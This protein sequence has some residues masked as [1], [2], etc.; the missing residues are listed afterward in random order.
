MLNALKLVFKEVYK[1]QVHQL[2]VSL[3]TLNFKQA[4]QPTHTLSHTW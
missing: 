3:W 1:S 4:T 2:V